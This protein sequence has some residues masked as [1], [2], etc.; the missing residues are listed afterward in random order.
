LLASTDA[1]VQFVGGDTCADTLPLIASLRKQNKGTLLAYS[2]EV[3]ENNSEG[4]EGQWKK[5]VQEMRASVDFA[6]DFEDMQG[7]KGSRRTWVAI[8][9]VRKFRSIPHGDICVTDGEV[10]CTSSCS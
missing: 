6:G 2:V 9:L 3:D 8:K 1:F 4:R 7:Q 5:N 10:E